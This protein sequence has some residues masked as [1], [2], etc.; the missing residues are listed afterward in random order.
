MSNLTTTCYQIDS[1]RPQPEPEFPSSR[2]PGVSKG[3]SILYTDA[4]VETQTSHEEAEEINRSSIRR[5]RYIRLDREMELN[6]MET[7]S[8]GC[9]FYILARACCSEAQ[10]YLD[11]LVREYWEE[12]TNI[13]GS[14]A[15]ATLLHRSE[16]YHFLSNLILP[17]GFI[18][19][20]EQTSLLECGKYHLPADLTEARLKIA[21]S[22]RRLITPGICDTTKILSDPAQSAAPP[23]AESP[24]TIHDHLFLQRQMEID[25]SNI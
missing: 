22:K 2:T 17:A 8:E 14:W 11:N 21:L 4:Q 19:N 20:I 18:S 23:R 3:P 1:S 7:S 13:R 10:A 16:I 6:E 24:A 15:R 9:W 5:K 25:L 12:I